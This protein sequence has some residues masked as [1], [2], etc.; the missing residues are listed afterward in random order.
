MKINYAF[1][2]HGF[3]CHNAMTSLLKNDVLSYDSVK[4][5][6]RG[7]AQA[8][9]KEFADPELT[10]LGVEASIHNGCVV[11]KTIRR[12]SKILNNTKYEISSVNIV[13]CSPLIRSMETAYYMT[14]KW[15]NPPNKIYVFPHLREINE[16]EGSDI[17]SKESYDIMETVP[18]Y[19]MKTIQEQKDHLRRHGMLEY[20]D[21]TFVENDEKRRKMPGDIKMFIGWFM[22]NFITLLDI[23][24]KSDFPLNVFL[25]T[26]HGVLHDYSKRNYHNNSGF[27][28][29]S[30]DT[31]GFIRAENVFLD[32]YLPDSFFTNYQ[33]QKFADKKYYCP[34]NRCK[35]ICS[36][37]RSTRLEKPY[38]GE[39]KNTDADN[40]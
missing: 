31:Y 1:L 33:N 11:S 32:E 14:R 4:V 35:S 16:S 38:V 29:Y 7:N 40:L 3:G 21:F 2:R 19:A 27:V 39:C 28:V 37:V 22:K 30:D 24:K 10:P 18:A 23:D 25:I 8:E 6:S 13:G 5:Y 34:S 9:A 17:Y 12:L 26:H 15:K 20:F 36:A